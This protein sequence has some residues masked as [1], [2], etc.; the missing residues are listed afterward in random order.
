MG[1]FCVEL[2]TPTN[3]KCEILTAVT[4]GLCSTSDNKKDIT[5]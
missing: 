3:I 2:V 5:K 1:K 4:V